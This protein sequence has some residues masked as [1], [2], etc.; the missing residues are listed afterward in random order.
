[1]EEIIYKERRGTDCE[2]WDALT[3]KF[4]SPELLSPRV[5]HLGKPAL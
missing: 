2:K 5:C 1:M 3:E 4:G